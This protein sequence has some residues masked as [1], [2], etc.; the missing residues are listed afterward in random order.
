MAHPEYPLLELAYDNKHHGHLISDNHEVEWEPYSHA[1]LDNF[2]FSPMCRRDTTMWRST[3][4]LIFFHVVEMHLPQRV[5]RQFDDFGNDTFEI[6]KENGYDDGI[7]LGWEDVDL[8]E[9]VVE[10]VCEDDVGD[11]VETEELDEETSQLP[12]GQ[13]DDDRFNY[14]ERELQLLKEVHVE[15]PSTANAK[16]ISMC[17]KARVRRSCH[18]MALRL[19]CMSAQDV[20]HAPPSAAT[21]TASGASR[22]TPARSVSTTSHATSA[23]AARASG[24]RGKEPAEES[25][26]DARNRS[27]EQDNPTYGEELQMS[28]LFDAPP[29]TQTQGESSQVATPTER[30]LRIHR[31]TRDHTDI[32]SANILPTDP[33]RQRRPRDPFSPPDQRRRQN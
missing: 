3:T 33:P 28:Q 12:S 21:A 14:T 7:S 31:R 20:A 9:V 17:H 24:S 30:E 11:G 26:D 29:P 15:L 2:E 10:D 5:M 32:G 8:D 19:N 18:R 25:D 22:R 23:A 16:D 6:D 4:P 27:S 13:H 1:G